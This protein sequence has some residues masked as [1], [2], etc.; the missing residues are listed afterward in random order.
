M[1][2]KKQTNS[3]QAASG[4]GRRAAVEAKSGSS[5][6]GGDLPP[7]VRAIYADFR[8]W[9]ENLPLPGEMEVRRRLSES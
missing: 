5:P 6:E 9:V 8:C 2:T 3:K 4:I 7:Q 1:P